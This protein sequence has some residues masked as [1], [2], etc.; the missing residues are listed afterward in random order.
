M[1]THPFCVLADVITTPKDSQMKIFSNTEEAKEIL[2]FSCLE[3]LPEIFVNKVHA[4]RYLKNGTECQSC[5]FGK[6]LL[7]SI[8]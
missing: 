2:G 5:I 1:L 4:A 7:D 3:F 8:Y 6:Y